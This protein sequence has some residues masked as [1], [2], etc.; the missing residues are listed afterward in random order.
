[1]KNNFIEVDTSSI[2]YDFTDKS[3]P[4]EEWLKTS[5]RLM[6]IPP[7][8]VPVF[9]QTDVRAGFLSPSK[10]NNNTAKH[11]AVTNNLNIVIN[12]TNLSAAELEDRVA[13]NILNALKSAR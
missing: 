3:L 9:M 5:N 6:N 10:L 12:G 1:M 11:D 8:S 2:M 4:F 7:E 13:S